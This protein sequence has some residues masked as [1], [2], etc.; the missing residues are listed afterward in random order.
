MHLMNYNYVITAQIRKG[1]KDKKCSSA[2]TSNATRQS[3]AASNGL[4][5]LNKKSDESPLPGQYHRICQI[6]CDYIEDWRDLGRCLDI[7]DGDLNRIGLDQC[8]QHNIKLMTNRV[9]EQ[10]QEKFRDGFVESLCTAL[11]E[12][13]RKDILRKLKELNLINY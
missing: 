3:T 11:K 4:T 12:A 8:L 9:L 5:I 2:S 7:T 13:R 10:A 6:V 1:Q